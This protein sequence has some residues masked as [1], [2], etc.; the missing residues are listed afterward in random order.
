MQRNDI[1]GTGAPRGLLRSSIYEEVSDKL[2]IITCFLSVVHSPTRFLG[3]SQSDFV[4]ARLSLVL[5]ASD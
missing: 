4:K 2:L 1:I 3:I 5:Q